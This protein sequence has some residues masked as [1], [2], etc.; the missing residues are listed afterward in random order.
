MNFLAHLYLSGGDSKLMAGNFIAD[1]VKG[2]SALQ[3]FEH[4]I[5]KGIELHRSIDEFTDTHPVVTKSKNRLRPKFRHYS[6]VITDVFYDHYLASNWDDYKTEPL[7]VFASNAYQTIQSFDEILPPDVKQMLP[8]MIRGNWLVNYG[9][10]EGI[11][12]ALSGMARRTP[13]DSKMDEAIHELVRYYDDFKNEF[14][15]FFPEIREYCESWIR[16]FNQART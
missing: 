16:K 7:P 3:K 11:H 4:D 1:F 5:V 13:Y 10:T 15:I 14:V 8:Y 12:R 6:G 9:K 2:R